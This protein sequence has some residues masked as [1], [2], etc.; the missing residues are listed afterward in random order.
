MANFFKNNKTFKK[1]QYKR[2]KVEADNSQI[3]ETNQG[4]L[5]L[6]GKVVKSQT[7]S[8]FQVEVCL[9]ERNFLIN[10]YLCGRLCQYKIR[11]IESD[12]VVVE[13]LKNELKSAAE[14][15]QNKING[16]ITQRKDPPKKEDTEAETK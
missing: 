15:S 13:V 16:R 11:V 12:I 6:E 14:S 2:Q 8:R 4:Y 3:K 7:G 10:A 5:V 1:Q 9:G